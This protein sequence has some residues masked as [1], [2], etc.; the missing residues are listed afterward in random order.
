[1]HDNK[2]QDNFNNRMYSESKIR[3]FRRSLSACP[4]GWNLESKLLEVSF[5]SIEGADEQ[6]I[7]LK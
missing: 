7:C 2:N 1:M 3:K 4:T 5:I 6:R